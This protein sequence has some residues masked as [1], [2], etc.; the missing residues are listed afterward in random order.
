L[1]DAWIMP[2]GTLVD[3]ETDD[4]FIVPGAD[5]AGFSQTLAHWLVPGLRHDDA[6]TRSLSTEI[7]SRVL[8]RIG[9]GVD[10]GGTWGAWDGRWQ[11]GPLTAHARTAAADYIGE[12]ARA[13]A[14]RRRLAELRERET[15]LAVIRASLAAEG[16]TLAGRRAGADAEAQSFPDHEPLRTAGAALGLSL[17]ALA[18]AGDAVAA[19]R[20]AEDEARRRHDETRQRRDADAGDLGLLAWIDRLD[21]LGEA[22]HAYELALAQLWPALAAWGRAESDAVR[23]RESA[24]HARQQHV[25]WQARTRT[26]LEQHEEIRGRLNAL[27]ATVGATEEEILRRE[28]EQRAEVQR[29]TEALKR[30]DESLRQTESTLARAGAEIE[31]YT[32]ERTERDAARQEQFVRL[33]HLVEEGLVGEAEPALVGD[34]FPDWSATRLV[35]LARGIEEN[36]QDAPRDDATWTEVQSQIYHRVNALDD[37]LVPHGIR[38]DTRAIDDGLVAVR[39]PFQGRMCQPGEYA[40]ALAGDLEHRERLLNQREREVIENHLLGDAAVELQTLLRRAEEWV[41][42]TNAELLARPTSTGMQL[43]FAWEPD[44]EG[45]PGLDAARR[46]LRRKNALWTPEDRAGLAGFLQQRI[47]AERTA[48]P[49][50]TWRDHLGAALDYRRWHRFSVLRQQNG[51]WLRLTRRTYGTGSGGEK[52]LA[53]TVPQFAAAAAHYRSASPHAPRLILLDEVFVGIDSDM[54]AKC[55]G[56]LTTFDLDFVLSSVRVWGCY[57]TMPGLAICQLT[58]R[59]G[60]DAVLVTRWVWNGS[61]LREASQ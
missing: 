15:Q 28:S 42:Q 24:A 36:L 32:Q 6:N 25:D 61:E 34:D 33:Q 20:L 54:R 51:Q 1:L 43:K 7:L 12:A 46:C 27:L 55:V 56:L 44:P 18:L 13:A 53:L 10:Q 17:A 30:A 4:T 37:A 57:P 41:E 9:A 23:T 47:E 16:E 49:D 8:A 5:A 3:P 11:L 38:P 31:R 29:L 60:V 45:P 50:R 39:C 26:A 2:D 19:A 14:R 21:A 22:L 52:A 35:E 48:A 58:A 59:P 40:R